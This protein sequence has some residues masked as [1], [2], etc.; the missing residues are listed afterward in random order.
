MDY[1]LLFSRLLL[2]FFD[3]ITLLCFFVLEVVPALF[4]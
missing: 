2:R 4:C 3:V 1:V